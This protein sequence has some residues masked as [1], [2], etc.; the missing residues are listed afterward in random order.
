MLA[1]EL[2]FRAGGLVRVRPILFGPLM[3]H[4]DAVAS[5]ELE[6]RPEIA[7]EILAGHSMQRGDIL[8]V[9]SNSGSNA[10]ASRLAQRARESGVRVIA[11]TSVR[12]ATASEARSSELPR[13]HELADVVIDNGGVVGDAA[14]DIPGFDRRVGPTSTVV[15]A[16]IVNAIVAE[17]VQIL[18]ERGT[19]PEVYTSS[20]VEGG[21]EINAPLLRDAGLR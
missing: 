3:L 19:P 21:D 18:V 13:V 10:V 8:V 1:E 4:E 17:A 6:R 20:N 5:T 15:A 11:V 9:A 7:D 16:A 2:F 14:V 12:H